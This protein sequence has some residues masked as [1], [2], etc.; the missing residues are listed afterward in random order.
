MA[1]EALAGFGSPAHRKAGQALVAEAVRRVAARLGNTPA[2]CRS[3]YVHPQ[4]IARFLDDDFP[5]SLDAKATLALVGEGL[6]ARGGGDLG[7]ARGR[8]LKPPCCGHRF[9]AISR[10][11]LRE[12]TMRNLIT[13]VPGVKV[14]HADDAR[15]ASGVTVIRFDEPAVASGA[16]RAA[17][18]AASTR[19]CS[20][21]R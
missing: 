17:R 5:W 18:Q 19:G 14:G 6:E 12:A 9:H 20:N 13:D 10:A 2:V 16:S 3:S 1:A 7:A 11:D 21:P 15:L 8:V 4:V